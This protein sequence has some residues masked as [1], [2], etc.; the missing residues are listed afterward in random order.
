MTLEEQDLALAREIE[1]KSSW[2]QRP[3]G[4]IPWHVAMNVARW[5]LEHERRLARKRVRAAK[6]ECKATLAQI[7]AAHVRRAK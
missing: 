4:D 3:A 1:A 2:E 6:R 7:V 5:Q